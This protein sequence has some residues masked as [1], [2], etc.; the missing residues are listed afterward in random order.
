MTIK[1]SILQSPSQGL[2]I[3]LILFGCVAGPFCFLYRFYFE[4]YSHNDF[5][6]ILFLSLA[7]GVPVSLAMSFFNALMIGI[8]KLKAQDV[9]M[10]W[11]LR[12]IGFTSGFCGFVYYSACFIDWLVL[13]VS[14][15]D[16]IE[17]MLYSYAGAIS[18]SI[19]RA[20][21]T[22]TIKNKRK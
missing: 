12:I 21:R 14:P 20:I 17:L 5:V 4:L 8:P 6:K 22:K 3:L 9:K 18:F 19:I 2:N 10:E 1:L 7:I 11:E 13:G 16:G 15:K